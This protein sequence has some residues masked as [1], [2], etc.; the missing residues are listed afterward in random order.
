MT[1]LPP[2]GKVLKSGS[3]K[4]TTILKALGSGGQG[5]VYLA[6]WGDAGQFAVKWYYPQSATH[7]Q[8]EAL[9]L[10]IKDAAPSA[11]FLWPLDLVDDPGSGSFGYIMRFERRATGG[12]TNMSPAG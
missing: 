12:C 8:G 6:D 1:D 9:R 2:P 7:E 11:K 3:G 5:E 10:L 4:P